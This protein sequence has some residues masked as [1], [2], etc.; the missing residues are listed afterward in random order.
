M[1]GQSQE[2]DL[3]KC[4]DGNLDNSRTRWTETDVDGFAVVLITTM[5]SLDK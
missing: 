5:K 2:R 1:Y 4:E 3:I